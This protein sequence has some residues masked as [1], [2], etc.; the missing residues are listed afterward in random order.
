ML[1][2]VNAEAFFWMLSMDT[3]LMAD[4]GTE[5]GRVKCHI[6]FEARLVWENSFESVGVEGEAVLL[7]SEKPGGG[8]YCGIGAAEGFVT[9]GVF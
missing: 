8:L 7:A 6:C 1:L 5:T 4:T 2:Y 3:D 9:G